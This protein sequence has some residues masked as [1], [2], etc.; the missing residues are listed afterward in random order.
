M[1]FFGVHMFDILRSVEFFIQKM[2]FWYH[3]RRIWIKLRFL[4]L[5]NSSNFDFHSSPSKLVNKPSSLSISNPSISSLNLCNLMSR[6]P[7]STLLHSLMS[8]FNPST[9]DFNTKPTHPLA[10][11]FLQYPT[12]LE[13]F[14]PKVIKTKQLR[15][16]I[17]STHFQHQGT[18]IR[19]NPRN[20]PKQ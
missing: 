4:L 19:N 12:E 20:S 18:M 5:H 9:L 13:V 15:T 8:T 7:Y 2:K 14:K 17:G 11:Y 6:F 10:P 3:L 16:P 1:I